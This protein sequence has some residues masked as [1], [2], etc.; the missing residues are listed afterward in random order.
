MIILIGITKGLLLLLQLITADVWNLYI[1]YLYI[2]K[3]LKGHIKPLAVR[4]LVRVFFLDLF[5]VIYL[6]DLGVDKKHLS[7]MKSFLLNDM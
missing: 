7:G 5:V 1:R 3:S 2:F 4:F 6:T